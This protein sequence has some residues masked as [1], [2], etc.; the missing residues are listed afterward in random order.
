MT[1]YVKAKCWFTMSR[2]SGAGNIDAVYLSLP[3]T[4]KEAMAQRKFSSSEVL[5]CRAE[6]YLCFMCFPLSQWCIATAEYSHDACASEDP[7]QT[8]M[9]RSVVKCFCKKRYRL[10]VFFMMCSVPYTFWTKRWCRHQS[11]QVKEALSCQ[12]GL[13]RTAQ[14]G[15]RMGLRYINEWIPVWLILLPK[16]IIFTAISS[17]L[18]GSQRFSS[19]D[20]KYSCCYSTWRGK[21]RLG[22]DISPCPKKHVE[23]PRTC[24][25]FWASCDAS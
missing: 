3:H 12:K 6:L 5:C 8:V 17:A 19:R 9:S 14:W 7:W 1:E 10:E 18:W 16:M 24:S 23:E 22:R 2:S 4:L 25:Q 15:S 13:L 11:C 21:R 20:W